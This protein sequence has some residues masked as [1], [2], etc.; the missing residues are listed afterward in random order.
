MVRLNCRIPGTHLSWKIYWPDPGLRDSLM[1]WKWQWKQ[2][3]THSGRHI[4]RENS[5]QTYRLNCPDFRLNAH[6]FPPSTGCVCACMLSRFS[7]VWLFA[8]LWTVAL[9]VSLSMGILQG[10]ILEWVAMPSSR[11]SS[12]PRDWTWVS[13][14]SCIGRWVLYH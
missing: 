8:T 13:F 11:A 6:L 9:Q 14:V 5:F 4:G 1:I 7:H 10:R 3:L 12:R 2:T